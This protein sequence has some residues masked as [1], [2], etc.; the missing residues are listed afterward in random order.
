M[1]WA[2]ADADNLVLSNNVM[3]CSTCTHVRF[4]DDTSFNP[5][6]DGNTFNGGNIGVSTDDIE[7]VNINGNTFNNQADFAIEV[8]NGDFNAD[9]NTINN[10]GQY[11]I[12]AD[13]LEEPSELAISVVAGVNTDY[14]DSP[15]EFLT[16]TQGWG[17]A[18]PCIS[19]DVY[20]TNSAG[21]EMIIRLIA[22]SYASELRIHVKAPDNTVTI[23]DP[24]TG[25]FQ[26]SGEES[27]N[28]GNPSPLIM[29][30]V[31]VYVLLEIRMVTV[32]MVEDLRLYNL[33]QEHGLQQDLVMRLNSG[34]L[35]LQDYYQQNQ[36][37]TE[38]VTHGI[39][40]QPL[41]L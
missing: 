9:G 28:S 19:P 38:R 16:W 2:D 20:A 31:G 33:M 39:H 30:Q 21:Q 12:Y 1:G 6:I 17:C 22:G 4:Q 25:D 5:L 8:E 11:A 14:A 7:R 35:V 10:P 29:D 41:L 34:T 13:S 26:P 15:G 23:W 27:H 18:N 37:V 36:P 32:Q 3:S 24:A 40:Q